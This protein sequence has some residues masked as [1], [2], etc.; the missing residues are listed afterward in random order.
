MLDEA[1]AAIGMDPLEFRLDMLSR[2][3]GDVSIDRQ[4][5]S[6]VLKLAAKKVTGGL[7]LPGMM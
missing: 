5:S 7:G 4:R 6:D 3:Y 2:S 1:A